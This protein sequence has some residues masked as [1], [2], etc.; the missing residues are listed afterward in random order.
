MSD[1]DD[2]EIDQLLAGGRLSAR[3]YDEIERRVLRQVAP[4]RARRHWPALGGVAVLASAFS[5]WLLMARSGPEELGHD[6]TRREALDAFSEKGS[7]APG[8]GA[9]VFDLRCATPSGAC[10]VGDTLM[11]SAHGVRQAGYL[12]A[13]AERS[14]DAKR[15]RIWYFPSESGVSPRIEATLETV[16]VPQGIELAAPHTPGRY[17][18]TLWL[19]DG[20]VRRVPPTEGPRRV[21]SFVI[22]D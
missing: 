8:G 12:V 6:G 10:R 20:P 15:E 13:Y 17:E 3:Q 14:G 11:V 22:A 19:S 4:R 7:G 18:V 2:L 9:P 1:N 5:A 21:L 16:V